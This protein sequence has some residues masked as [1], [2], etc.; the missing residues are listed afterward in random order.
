MGR[1]GRRLVVTAAAAVAAVILGS[2]ASAVSTPDPADDFLADCAPDSAGQPG[3]PAMDLR[4]AEAV[5]GLDGMLRLSVETGGDALGYM[6]S[7]PPSA[8]IAFYLED[9][10]QTSRVSVVHEIHEGAVRTEAHLGS[11]QI[12]TALDV[13]PGGP[14][15]VS[16]TTG[17]D[18]RDMDLAWYRVTTFV[19]PPGGTFIC[20][21]L[22]AQ[23]APLAVTEE[24]PATTTTRAATSTTEAPSATGAPSTAGAGAVATGAV[25]SAPGAEG[26]AGGEGGDSGGD[27]F[28]GMSWWLL[29]LAAAFAL[30]GVGGL[31]WW[32]QRVRGGGARAADSIDRLFGEHPPQG[33]A[34]HGAPR[35]PPPGGNEFGE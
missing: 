11:E 17:I 24:V 12:D 6:A 20:D 27:G 30:F 34:S 29:L 14:N 10:S 35:D 5:I 31:W 1:V 15:T 28:F 26:G 22:G 9:A 8:A 25:T 3:E 16:I 21:L 13:A 23:D 4:S 2:A 18:A 7:K 33:G 19:T 32:F